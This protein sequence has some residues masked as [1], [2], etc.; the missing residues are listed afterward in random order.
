LSAK[1]ACRIAVAVLALVVSRH[2]IA[3]DPAEAAVDPSVLER[4]QA[5][6]YL[7]GVERAPERTGVLAHDRR[8]AQAG[9]N[10]YVA[11]DA[12][13]ARL[14]DMDGTLLH[15]WRV[16]FDAMQDR[17]TARRGLDRADLAYVRRAHLF[18][19]GDVL[20]VLNDMALVKLDAHS[21]ILWR[22]FGRPHHD[23]DVGPD[24]SVWT[25]GRVERPFPLPARG[26]VLDDEIVRLDAAGHELDRLSLSVALL[27]GGHRR[28]MEQAGAMIR[29]PAAPFGDVFHTNSIEVLDGRLA[30]RLPAF[31]AGALLVSCPLLHVVMVVDMEERAVTWTLQGDFRY[32]HHPTVVD[33]GRLL[34]FDNQRGDDR[35]SRV[36][37]LDPVSGAEAWG[38][39]GGDD[40]PMY[41]WCCGTCHRLP[42]GNTLI[43]ETQAGRAIEVTAG[44]EIVWE[45]VVP[46]RTG[47]DGTRIAQLFDLVRVDGL[48]P[49]AWATHGG[50]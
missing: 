15:R 28:L 29:T 34:L 25:I 46:H 45:F 14:V 42:N 30:D 39:G 10:F 22:R 20:A 37:E 24:G 3:S 5:L 1:H 44:G 31:R 32:Q 7:E 33:A 17:E 18:P 26:L 8:R 16:D 12:P 6:G 23:V 9:L 27:N 21:R 43:V 13:E 11:G 47:P 19:N 36:R 48:R 41:S 38:Y 49:P 4:L 35:H 40:E 50:S 2:G